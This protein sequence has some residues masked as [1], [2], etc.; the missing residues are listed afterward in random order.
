MT[1]EVV[2]VDYGVGNLRSVTRAVAHCGMTPV[3]TSVTCVT[4]P[5]RVDR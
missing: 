1:S 3:L 4:T 5:F 2:I